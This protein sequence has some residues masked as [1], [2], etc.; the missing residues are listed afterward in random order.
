MGILC[1]TF[2]LAGVSACSPWA[3]TCLLQCEWLLGGWVPLWLWYLFNG[4][5]TPLE[6]IKALTSMF[7][8]SVSILWCSKREKRRQCDHYTRARVSSGAHLEPRY[9]IR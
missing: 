2:F 7:V 4:L 3:R 6:C 5:P 8:V 1:L 9:R